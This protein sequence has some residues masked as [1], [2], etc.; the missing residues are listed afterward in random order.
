MGFLAFVNHAINFL[1]PAFWMALLMPLGARIILKK[2]ST[3][4]SMKGLIALHLIVGCM[5]LAGGLVVFGHDGKMLTYLIL[6]LAVASTQWVLSR[7]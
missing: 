4:I 5:V 1:A 3:A 7:R 6:V 2:T